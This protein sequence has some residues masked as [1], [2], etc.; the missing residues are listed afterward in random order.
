MSSPYNGL[1]P[2]IRAVHMGLFPTLGSLQ[3]VF[4]LADSKVPVISKNEMFS[5]LATYHNTLLKTIQE[6][7]TQQN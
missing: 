1:Q 3:E 5:L 7:T 2:H 4:D 6:Q